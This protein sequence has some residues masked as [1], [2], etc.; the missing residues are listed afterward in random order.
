[1]LSA[2]GGGALLHFAAELRLPV[3]AVGFVPLWVVLL[4]LLLSASDVGFV[5]CF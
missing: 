3:A 2:A 4:L 5:R 1:M